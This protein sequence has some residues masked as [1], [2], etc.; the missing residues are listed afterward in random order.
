MKNQ[1]CYDKDGNFLGWFSRSCAVVGLVYCIKNNNTYILISKRGKGTPDPEFI[2][3]WNLVCG[4]LDFEE[5]LDKAIMREVW[6]ETGINNFTKIK[7][8]S[9]NSDPKNDKRQNITFRYVLET[10]EL[11]TPIS[12]N[13]EPDEVEESKWVNIN[14]IDNY[15]WAFNHKELVKQLLF[16]VS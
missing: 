12:D 10:D 7:P 6:E 16:Y 14:D 13:C 4:Y 15:E 5:D 11:Y 1:P 9:V 3:K 8:V 2:G